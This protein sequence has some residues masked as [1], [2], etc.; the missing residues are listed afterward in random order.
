MYRFFIFLLV[1]ALS[2]WVGVKITADPGYMLITW[3]QLALEM[4]LW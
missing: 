1:L 3:H 4:P 2:V